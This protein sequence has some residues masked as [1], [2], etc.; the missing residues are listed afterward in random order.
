LKAG[1]TYPAT[2]ALAAHLRARLTAMHI[3][4]RLSRSK[5]FADAVDEVSLAEVRRLFDRAS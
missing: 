1:A 2:I 5:P 3:P 4:T